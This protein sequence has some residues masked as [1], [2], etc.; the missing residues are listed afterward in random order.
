MSS[1]AAALVSIVGVLAI[2]S[3]SRSA[4]A[5]TPAEA[6]QQLHQNLSGF[7]SF[8]A[9]GAGTGVSQGTFPNGVTQSGAVTGWY[10]DPSNMNHGFLRTPEGSI[11]TFDAPGAGTG[12]FQGTI[13]FG[14]NSAGADHGSL[15]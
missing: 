12:P 11:T 7:V 15:F 3:L 2:L 9:P 1:R 13:A 8:D 5:D 4:V 10:V 14:M 6:G